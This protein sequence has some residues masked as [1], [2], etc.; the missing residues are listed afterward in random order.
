MYLFSILIFVLH[1]IFFYIIMDD[2]RPHMWTRFIMEIEMTTIVAPPLVEG[3]SSSMVVAPPLLQLSIVKRCHKKKSWMMKQILEGVGVILLLLTS[4]T[5]MKRSGGVLTNL[6]CHS[7]IGHT[8]T[9][10]TIV[11]Y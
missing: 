6:V 10:N 5:Y 8:F 9:P 11:N 2:G 4:L 1:M 7:N 3:S